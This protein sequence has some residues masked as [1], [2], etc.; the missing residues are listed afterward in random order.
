M[1]YVIFYR[2]NNRKMEEGYDYEVV[3][4][5]LNGLNCVI[6]LKLM[7]DAIQMECKHGMCNG[8]FQNLAQSALERYSNKI[9][10]FYHN[11]FVY[12]Y[13]RLYDYLFK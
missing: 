6:C 8:C 1:E 9:Y 12:T 7:R 2:N 3:G 13:C 11:F 5:V 4:E 10:I